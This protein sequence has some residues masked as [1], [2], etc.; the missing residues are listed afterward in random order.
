[1][2]Y[3]FS[4]VMLFWVKV[5]EKQKAPH[6]VKSEG[7]ISIILATTYSRGTYRPTTIGAAAFHY[8]VRKGTGWGH[9][10]RVTRFR[11][12]VWSAYLISL[13]R[14]GMCT[15][16]QGGGIILSVFFLQG[17]LFAIRRLTSARE[18]VLYSKYE[19][20][21]LFLCCLALLASFS[22]KLGGNKVLLVNFK[23]NKKSI[24]N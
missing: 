21:F 24:G 5:A 18:S 14:A 23:V 22:Q 12:L 9:C 11:T 19:L 10:A 8:R 13:L 2:S 16:L 17:S 4:A 1:M 15:C 7:L 3:D 6:L 20:M